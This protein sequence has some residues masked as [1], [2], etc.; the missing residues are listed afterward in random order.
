VISGA[1]A[2]GHGGWQV[3]DQDGNELATGLRG[4]RMVVEDIVKHA[5][6]KT[7]A[8]NKPVSKPP[9]KL[10][11]KT[12]NKAPGRPL[13]TEAG[14]RVAVHF[15][16]RNKLWKV[17]LSGKYVGSFRASEQEQA[18]TMREMLEK[19]DSMADCEMI[20][21]DYREARGNR[22]GSRGSRKKTASS[23]KS[24]AKN[25]SE[26]EPASN[27]GRAGS[28]LEQLFEAYWHM[29]SPGSVAPERELRLIPGRRFRSDFVWRTEKVV[30]EVDGGQYQAHGGRHNTDT[31]REKLNELAIHGF[32]VLRF[33]GSMLKSDPAGCIETVR[34]CLGWKGQI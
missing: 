1:R 21:A 3:W 16:A 8:K 34:R 18:E 29:L 23:S 11:S 32:R 31:D 19:A 17:R 22:R 4:K 14:R 9:N 10:P 27:S 5:K 33:S 30:V 12:A 20:I 26:P 13:K 7:A 25:C 15:D 28:E 2:D 24:P 6:T